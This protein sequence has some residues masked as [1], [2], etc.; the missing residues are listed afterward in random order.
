MIKLS[1]DNLFFWRYF[2]GGGI[3]AM[4][5]FFIVF[6]LI[7]NFWLLYL[8]YAFMA[9][10]QFL[11]GKVWRYL[12]ITDVYLSNDFNTIEFKK[13]EN[14][15]ISFQCKQIIKCRTNHGITDL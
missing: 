3:L 6:V 9:A 7:V 1:K 4:H 12:L 5:C 10:L 11:V 13:T 14:E 15:A 2:F 8:I